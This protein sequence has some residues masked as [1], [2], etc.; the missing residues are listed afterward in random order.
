MVRTALL[1]GIVFC[2]A[3]LVLFAGCGPAAT[4]PLSLITPTPTPTPTLT[5]TPTPTSTPTPTP[6]PTQDVTTMDDGYKI[7]NVTND[8]IAYAEQAAGDD[9]AGRK[10]KWDQMLEGKYPNFFN[11]VLYRNLAGQDRENYKTQII[12]QFWNDVVPNLETL[13]EVNATA[14]Q[15]LLDGRTEFKKIFTNFDPQTDYYLTVA[16]SF[17]G[18][19]AEVAGKNILALGLENYE[20]NSPELDI[21]IAHEQFHL[22]H[23]KTFDASGGLYRGVWTEGMAVYAS[24]MV[25]P[26]YHL[27][28]YTGFTGQQIDS[29]Y[30]LF[31]DLAAD[32][33]NNLSST[34]QTLKRAYLGVE[35]NNTWIPPGSGYYIGFYLVEDLVGNGNSVADMAGWDANTVYSTM[36]NT[37]ANLQP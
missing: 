21:T 29:M 13:K 7:Y 32:I 24:A 8:F 18:K 31:G 35:A 15:K 26:G 28:D 36:Y 27:T 19:A 4:G 5:L 14:V 3:G 11:E 30:D 20:P 23:F 37:L 9:A 1:F 22:Y 34:D 16:F 2:G 6:T 12:D 25:V 10:T 33:R 17:H